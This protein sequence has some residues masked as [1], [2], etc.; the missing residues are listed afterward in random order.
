MEYHSNRKGN[1]VYTTIHELSADC[2][3]K[4]ILISFT[5]EGLR[6]LVKDIIKGTIRRGNTAEWNQGMATQVS[7]F[8][9][10]ELSGYDKEDSEFITT[11]T[12]TIT[13]PINTKNIE[14]KVIIH[15][16]IKRKN[17]DFADNPECGFCYKK[18]TKL[19]DANLLDA[20]KTPKKVCNS[21]RKELNTMRKIVMEMRD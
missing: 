14:R 9:E 3:N 17:P 2:D 15:H 6:E 18:A 20:A 11:S 8:R 13:G 19:Y 10:A 5:K 4:H 7:M 16:V 21:C 12:H 1:R